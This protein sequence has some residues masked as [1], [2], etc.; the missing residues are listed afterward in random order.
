MRDGKVEYRYTLRDSKIECNRTPT[1]DAE[2]LNVA[3]GVE[4]AVGELVFSEV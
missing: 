1:M 2:Q 4:E 3:D